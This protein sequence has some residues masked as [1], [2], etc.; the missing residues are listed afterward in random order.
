MYVKI[1]SIFYE[2]FHKEFGEMSWHSLIVLQVFLMSGLTED[3]CVLYLL[4][5]LPCCG[6]THG[7]VPRKLYCALELMR[8]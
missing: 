8:E 5:H 7:G 2:Y 4:W 1:S 3:S 6:V